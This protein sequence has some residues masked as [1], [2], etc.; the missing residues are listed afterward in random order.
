MKY[1]T[2]IFIGAAIA[3]AGIA[4]LAANHYLA[5]K[6]QALIARFDTSQ[7]EIE[8]IVPKLDLVPGDVISFDNVSVR[9][10]P[11]QY[12]AAGFLAPS[13]FES[14]EGMTLKETVP[15]G[16]PLL[17]S[18]IDGIAGVD[19]FSQLV[20]VGYRA[21][22]INADN[23]KSNESLILPGDVVDV[24]VK[25]EGEGDTSRIEIVTTKA[26]VLAIDFITIAESRVLQKEL[27]A[28]GYSTLTLE[29]KA[30]TAPLMLSAIAD[31]E[32]Y[33]LVR[34]ELDPKSNGYGKLE[35]FAGADGAT[36][37]V[38]V[39]SLTSADGPSIVPKVMNK[40]A[41]SF[42]NWSE[43]SDRLYKK[44]TPSDS[45]VTDSQVASA[46]PN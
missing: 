39:Y 29:V 3:F 30:S 8:V 7:N 45:N 27:S 40:S 41:V 11:Q 28:E 43:N 21:I 35:Y 38:K 4:V 18:Q 5:A 22:T 42:N 13:V 44:F 37:G 34:N 19:R 1:K 23:L 9:R 17:K 24:L 2:G 32:V 26:K 36:N 31:G 6:E 15:L 33:T 12:L 25:F 14:I 20:R 16:S 46:E 10:I